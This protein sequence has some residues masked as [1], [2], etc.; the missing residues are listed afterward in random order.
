MVYRFVVANTVDEHMLNT[1]ESKRKL[2]KMVIHKNKFKGEKKNET[3]H[4]STQ[5]IAS[6]VVILS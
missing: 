5:G 6:V 3:F 1:A 4:I 2:E